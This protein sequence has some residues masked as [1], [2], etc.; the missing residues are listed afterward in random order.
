MCQFFVQVHWMA[1]CTSWIIEDHSDNVWSF[2]PMYK[3][4]L[5]WEGCL[6]IHLSLKMFHL[7]CS[8]KKLCQ[9]FC[10]SVYSIL[11]NHSD[12]VREVLM[13]SWQCTLIYSHIRCFKPTALGFLPRPVTRNVVICLALTR[14]YASLFV[15]VL[16]WC[17]RIYQSDNIREVLNSVLRFIP[18]PINQS[19]V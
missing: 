6:A 2:L 13:E 15:H 8:Y 11:I 9:S 19:V 12:K 3:L 7:F 17:L 18:R 14:K 1:I 5:L 10:V 4:A 16:H